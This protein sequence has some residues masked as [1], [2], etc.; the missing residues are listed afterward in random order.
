MHWTPTGC[1]VWGEELG[2]NQRWVKH[3]RPW[4]EGESYTERSEMERLKVTEAIKE[5]MGAQEYQGGGFLRASWKRWLFSQMLK[6]G[7][8]MECGLTVQRK[9]LCCGWVLQVPSPLK[10]KSYSPASF[11]FNLQSTLNKTWTS[12]SYR[13]ACV[14]QTQLSELSFHHL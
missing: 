2:S 9:V 6:H 11:L 12:V 4:K 8:A 7:H 1:Q 13:P 10:A 3:R 14:P 5:I